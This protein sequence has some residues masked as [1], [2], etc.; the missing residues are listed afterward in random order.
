M[1]TIETVATVTEDGRVTVKVPGVA[2][3]PHRITV[4]I[5][6][7]ICAEEP[8]YLKGR[9]VYTAKECETRDCPYPP[10]PEWVAEI[11]KQAHERR[12]RG[13]LD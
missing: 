8:R 7:S 11:R 9:R 2:P 3:G 10:E 5:E 13:E 6:D 1:T 12:E 4:N